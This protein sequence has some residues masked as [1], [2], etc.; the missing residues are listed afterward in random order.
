MQLSSIDDQLQS[1]SVRNEIKHTRRYNIYIF[2]WC[3]LWLLPYITVVL[4]EGVYDCMLKR[5]DASLTQLMHVVDAAANDDR[6][7]IIIVFVHKCRHKCIRRQGDCRCKSINLNIFVNICE[8]ANRDLEAKQWFWYCNLAFI[9]VIFNFAM[10]KWM[11][12]A[13]KKYW[14]DIYAFIDSVWYGKN[15]VI[16]NVQCNYMYIK[17]SFKLIRKN[18]DFFLNM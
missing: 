9:E 16:K 7:N 3:C 1:A 2:C 10:W 11:L 15:C 5:R 12:F 14:N 8:N 4:K 6:R 18:E 17:K 13:Y